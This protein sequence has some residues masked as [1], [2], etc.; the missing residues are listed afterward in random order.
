MCQTLGFSPFLPASHFSLIRVYK[1]GGYH[2]EGRFTDGGAE[3][4]VAWPS[5]HR[6]GSAESGLVRLLPT[7]CGQ[8]AAEALS[9]QGRGLLGCG[10]GAWCLALRVS[11]EAA[12]VETVAGEE[13]TWKVVCVW[14]EGWVVCDLISITCVQNLLFHCMRTPIHLS[15]CNS[16]VLKTAVFLV[17]K[18]IYV[19]CKQKLSSSSSSMLSL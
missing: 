14:G 2:C 6:G 10:G 7:P 9:G 12:G 3:E 8:A 16:K 17:M 15:R 4:G 11:S 1:G 5:S 13:S 19:N 18:I